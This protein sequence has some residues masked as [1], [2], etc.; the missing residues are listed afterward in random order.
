MSIDQHTCTISQAGPSMNN[1]GQ[2]P[3]PMVLFLMSDVKGAFSNYWFFAPQ[4][5][6]NQMLATAIAAMTS[7]MQVNVFVDTPNS[8][9]NPA[10]QV[11]NMY[12]QSY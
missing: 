9:N 11:Y 6:K 8:N 3:N 5:T 4:A 12:L 10:T 7:Q 1:E 2:T